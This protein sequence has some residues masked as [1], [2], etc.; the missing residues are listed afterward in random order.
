MCVSRH[1]RPLL[2]EQPPLSLLAPR[3]G[4]IQQGPGKQEQAEDLLSQA[5]GERGSGGE[6]GGVLPS[7]APGRDTGKAWG[8]RAA[9]VFM[10][11][12]EGKVSGSPVEGSPTPQIRTPLGGLMAG[13]GVSWGGLASSFPR[14]G[15]SP[16]PLFIRQIPANGR[17][18]CLKR[19]PVSQ[20]WT[21]L[22]DTGRES[23]LGQ[24]SG[25]SV[26]RS[27]NGTHPL[28]QGSRAPAR[29]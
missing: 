10:D 5:V 4:H 27:G 19:K 14:A 11:F 20:I 15:L 6:G 3:R 18:N 23:S 16:A 24:S 22:G 7:G 21:A 29:L 1:K 12:T 26:Q 13:G 28:P 25:G 9:T 8:R 2:L 17:P